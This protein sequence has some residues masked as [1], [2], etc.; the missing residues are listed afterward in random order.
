MTEI[1]QRAAT[2]LVVT[3][4]DVI[5]H[6]LAFGKV[7]DCKTLF[8]LCLAL[9]QPIHRCSTHS[10]RR[11]HESYELCGTVVNGPVPR[12]GVGGCVSVIALPT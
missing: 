7:Q 8:D 6:L 10:V 3:A 1:G 12:G 9:Q 5:K 4:A 2:S 11:R